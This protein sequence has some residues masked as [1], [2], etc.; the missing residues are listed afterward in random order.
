MTDNNFKYS[1]ERYKELI[2]FYFEV[3]EL[4]TAAERDDV[5]QRLSIYAIT[6]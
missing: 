3:K 5:E 1:Y 4:I 2:K 6:Y